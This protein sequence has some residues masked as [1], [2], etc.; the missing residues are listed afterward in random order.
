MSLA[1]ATFGLEVD[2]GRVTDAAPIAR[3]AIGKPEREVADFYR[4]KGARFHRLP[5]RDSGAP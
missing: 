1:Y 2:G 3:W 4:G 5:V